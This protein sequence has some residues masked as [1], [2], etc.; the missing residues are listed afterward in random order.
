RPLKK[1]PVEAPFLLT[2]R[3]RLGFG[4][5]FVGEIPVD[6]MIEEGRDIVRTAVLIV[7]I[8]R[9]LPN[10]HGEERGR[11][12][13]ERAGRVRGLGDL[14][15]AAVEDEPGPAAAELRRAGILEL[16][17]ELVERAEVGVD[18]VGNR[19]GR[20]AAAIRLHRMPVESVVP[21]LRRIV[22]Y[23]G[24]RRIIGGVLHDLLE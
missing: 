2:A 17:N 16:L 20:L 3:R 1:A 22:E 6:E 5:I 12:V 18:L 24:F 19:A 9:M 14:Q 23:A 15:L 8:V 21:D 13:G 4:E 7:E 10:V 11:A